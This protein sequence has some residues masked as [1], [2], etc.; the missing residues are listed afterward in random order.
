VSVSP[1]ET[2]LFYEV[3]VD[4]YALLAGGRGMLCDLLV[5]T[6]GIVINDLEVL[7]EITLESKVEEFLSEDHEQ[8][9]M[10]M[11]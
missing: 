5:G 10:D 6:I 4:V 7:I 3:F 11:L 1:D 8:R 9:R 2:W